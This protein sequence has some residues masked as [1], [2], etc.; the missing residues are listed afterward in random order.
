MIHA[1][2]LSDYDALVKMESAGVN[3]HDKCSQRGNYPSVYEEKFMNNQNTLEEETYGESTTV[4][5]TSQLSDL[6]S[7]MH[8][9]Q[10][11]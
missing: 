2:T 5:L 7:S 9:F 1:D 6:L 8:L 4:Y 11:H 10:R 3:V